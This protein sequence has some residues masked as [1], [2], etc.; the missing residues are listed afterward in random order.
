MHFYWLN[1][2]DHTTSTEGRS[3]GKTTVF[4]VDPGVNKP[5]PHQPR[6]S[7]LDALSLR[8]YD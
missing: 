5:P 4:L 2:Q 7:I 6:S 8:P 1:R 3:R